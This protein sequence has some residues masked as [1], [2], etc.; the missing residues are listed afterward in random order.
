VHERLVETLRGEDEGAARTALAQLIAL[1]ENHVRKVLRE[2]V[3]NTADVEELLQD[4]WV[5]VWK[6]RKS[7]DE[8]G[9][10]PTWLA[11]IAVNVVNSRFRTKKSEGEV[12]VGVDQD[13]EQGV[14]HEPSDPD[15][16]IDRKYAARVLQLLARLDQL[17]Q[18]ERTKVLARHPDPLLDRLARLTDKQRRIILEHFGDQESPKPARASVLET[19]AFKLLRAIVDRTLGRSATRTK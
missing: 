19:S 6:K 15:R 7:I 2:H 3:R 9:A 16:A 8:L 5:L 18:E 13:P 11:R 14:A 17:P 1:F 12:L 10:F 4:T